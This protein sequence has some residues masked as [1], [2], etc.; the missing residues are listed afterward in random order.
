MV[1]Q[2][3]K[4][5]A[6][7]P[8][9]NGVILPHSEISQPIKT[10][11]PSPGAARTFW[12]SP[13]STEC[14]LPG[15][16][17]PFEMDHILS[18]GYVSPRASHLLRWHILVYG[19]FISLMGFPDSSVDKESACNAG[20][21]GSIPGLG[22]SPGEGK[23]YPLQYSGPGNSMDCI[24][25]GVTKWRTLLSSFHFIFNKTVFP[26]SSGAEPLA[27]QFVSFQASYT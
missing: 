1:T 7:S 9:K 10:N 3:L 5:F 22:R 24:V 2:F 19:V 12:Y 18:M 23:G 17:L 6:P 16:L 8:Q 11:T 27:Y 15:L 26:L 25:H 4:I 13:H 21:P 20:D 14:Y